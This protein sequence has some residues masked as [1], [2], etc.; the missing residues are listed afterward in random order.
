MYPC[1]SDSDDDDEND[2]ND[3]DDEGDWRKKKQYPFL[4]SSYSMVPL[5][6][7][8]RF[9]CSLPVIR[10]KNTTKLAYTSHVFRALC[11][12][13][14]DKFK[15]LLRTEKDTN[16]HTQTHRHIH[17]T[18]QEKKTEA[19]NIK[20]QVGEKIMQKNWFTKDMRTQNTEAAA[21]TAVDVFVAAFLSP[22]F[23]PP[24]QRTD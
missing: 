16:A 15:A 23:S 2:E 8:P 7:S 12:V 3:Y 11:K 18:T 13:I 10:K 19:H 17:T 24:F 22:L 9:A 21:T 14:Q 4:R 1:I 20:T 6:A 5:P